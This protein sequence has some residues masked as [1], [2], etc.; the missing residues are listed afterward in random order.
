MVTTYKLLRE[1][2][3]N[4]FALD[5]RALSLLRIG[6]ALLIWADLII[7]FSDLK[8]H[9]SDE[10]VLPLQVLFSNAWNGGWVSLHTMSGLWQV[11]AL[12]FVVAGFFAICLLV[13]YQVRISTFASWF[14]LMSLQNRNPMLNQGGDDLLRMTL[15]WGMFLP[16]GSY[17]SLRSLRHPEQKLRQTKYI[18]WAGAAYLIQ[19]A[20]VYFFSALLKD[21][22]E[23]T[24]EGTAIYY[25]LSLDQMVLPLGKLLY[26]HAEWLRFLTFGVY[27][28]E[29]FVPLLFFIPFYTS[30]FRV[31]A[32]C[33]LCILNLGIGLTLFVGLFFVIGMVTLLGLIPSS[34]MDR[35]Y[36]YTNI[37]KE[38][39]MDA[40]EAVEI[41]FLKHVHIKFV[42]R[43]PLLVRNAY[44]RSIRNAFVAFLLFYVL[45]SNCGTVQRI[46]YG[47]DSHLR[48]IGTLLRIDQNWGMFAPTVF[49]DDG[50]FVLEA[51]KMNGGWIDINQKGKPLQYAK[52]EKIVSL[53]K[54]DRWRKYSENILFISNSYLR[55]YYCHYALQKWNLQHPE[56][57]L[58]QLKVVYMKEV[59]LPNYQYSPPTHEVLCECSN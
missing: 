9:Y 4:I 27:Y 6:V 42:F 22:A 20:S 25:A 12:L 46:G 8:A 26:P 45:M 11:Q 50:W 33:L 2:V 14:L 18:G 34:G 10:G 19:I 31:L 28:L 58:T 32:I 36:G 47:P 3:L 38:L 30:F 37:F 43:F 29:C 7:R 41:F 51:K 54:N 59:S 5:L 24:Q 15:F 16:W 44:Y 35:W 55:P 17:F 39:A 48:W 56:Q 21:S 53:F 52:P 57:M 49:K 13:G 23:W 40:F 1:R